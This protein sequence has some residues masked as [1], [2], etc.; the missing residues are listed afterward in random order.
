MRSLK[1]LLRIYEAA[2]VRGDQPLANWAAKGM[3]DSAGTR[4]GTLGRGDAS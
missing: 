4:K 2:R 3:T 1:Q